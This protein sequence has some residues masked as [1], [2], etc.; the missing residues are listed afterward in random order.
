MNTTDSLLPT[1]EQDDYSAL[2]D[3]LSADINP[4][5]AQTSAAPAP[6]TTPV[7]PNQLSSLGNSGFTFGYAFNDD[8]AYWI[9]IEFYP[10]RAEGY[11]H[12]GG[13]V[14][15]QEHGHPSG[16]YYEQAGMISNPG[17]SRYVA[18]RRN[19][20]LAYTPPT[21]PPVWP[22]GHPTLSSLLTTTTT[23]GTHLQEGTPYGHFPPPPVTAAQ[24]GYPHH[25]P[26]YVA[27]YP[28]QPA[29]A[30][31]SYHPYQIQSS[32]RA[33]EYGFDGIAT[34]Y[35][36]PFEQRYVR[37]IIHPSV[38]MLKI[39]SSQLSYPPV[40]ER[41]SDPAGSCFSVRFGAPLH[42]CCC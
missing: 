40:V 21:T 33:H 16:S 27:G 10:R 6:P 28:Q 26:Q 8:G 25:L 2:F 17:P 11:D 22:I 34:A 38:P 7:P 15:Q 9:L 36:N 23:T 30:G 42:F 41:Q 4:F 32:T 5:A 19:S 31:P 14:Q 39:A 12:W 24:T 29:P 1:H 37:T 20:L 13:A 18:V 35:G 3:L